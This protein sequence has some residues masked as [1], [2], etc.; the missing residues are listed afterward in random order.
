MIFFL[1]LSAYALWRPDQR[2][3]FY[4]FLAI[5]AIFSGA[6]LLFKRNRATRLQT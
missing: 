3:G 6:Y 1:V 4:A 2:I 5:N